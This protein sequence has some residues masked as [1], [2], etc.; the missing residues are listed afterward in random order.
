MHKTPPCY[1][2]SHKKKTKAAHRE[3]KIV[4]QTSRLG[5]Y[6][7]KNLKYP[8]WFTVN[9]QLTV[10]RPGRA[11]ATWARNGQKGNH[12]VKVSKWFCLDTLNFQKFIRGPCLILEST[13]L[14]GNAE[15]V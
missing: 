12:Q 1:K 14:S 3:S 7:E 2:A 8:S 5:D 13:F 9:S 6:P 11:M 4:E 10:H 15:Y